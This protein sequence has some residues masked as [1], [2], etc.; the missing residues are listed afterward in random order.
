MRYDVLG[1]LEVSDDGR[2][3]EV[4]GRRQRALLAVLLLHANRV[5]PVERIVDALWGDEPP[6]TAAKAVQVL[7]S[8][9]RKALGPEPLVTKASGYM[10]RVGDGELDVDRFRRLAEE[11]RFAEALRLWRGP[12]L[13]EFAE[14]SFA[15]AEIARLDEQYLACV[16]ERVARDLDQGQRGELVGELERLVRE[17]PLRER[18]RAQLM[19]A[20][21]RSGRQAEALAAYQEARRTLV[22]ELGIEPGRALRELQQAI[23]QQNPILDL[24]DAGG[25]QRGAQRP[26]SSSFVARERELQE[27]F[28]GL[29]DAFARRARLFLVVG[30]PGIGKS[31]LCDEVIAHARA[32]GAQVLV[33][34]CWEAGGAPAYWPWVQALR[35]YVRDAD[36]A[37]LRAVL[38]TE[39]SDLAQLL[40]EL[41]ELF[42]DLPKP[43]AGE[44]EGARFRLFEAVASL[45]RAAAV[46]R[47]IVL[48][49]DDLHAADEP[50][51]VLLQFLARELG[52]D[53]LLVVGAYRDV[54]PTPTAPLRAALVEL[55]REPLTRTLALTGFDEDEVARFIEQVSGDEPSRQLVTAISD[56]TE[57]NPLFVSEILQ[58]IAAEGS[59]AAVAPK[60]VV[61]E[62]VREVILR[63]LRHLSKECRQAL[64][65]ASALGRE[66][67]LD[68]LAR[69]TNLSED[70][71]L[72]RLDEALA[73]GV[74]SD[75]PGASD[76]L[77]FAHV[78]IRDTLY[79][80][81][82][83]PRRVRLHRLTLQALEALETDELESHLAELAYHAVAASELDQG[84]SYACRAGDRALDSFAFE[85]AVRLYETA[86][87]ALDAAG[88]ADETLRYE[89]VLALGNARMLAGN[90]PAAKQ[91]FL[92]AADIARGTG[93]AERLARAALGYAGRG[94]WGP[95][96]EADATL[97]PLLEDALAQCG[98]V[99]SELLVNLLARLGSSLRGSI[100]RTRA[101][102]SVDRAVEIA[103]RLGDPRSLLFALGSR[104]AAI[105]TPETLVEMTSDGVDIV[106]LA[107][108]VGDADYE[109]SGRENLLYV[110]WT[111]GD[112]A[113]IA[114]E[115]AALAR[116]A[117]E[118]RQPA[119]TCSVA[120]YRAQIAL[121]EGELDE[122]EELI[123]ASA[124]A[125]DGADWITIASQRLQTFALRELRGDLDGYQD[126]IEA[127]LPMFP[128]YSILEC[129]LGAVYCRLGLDDEV[130]RL[131]DQLAR[132][133]FGQLSRD[134]DWL[135]NMSL[136]GDVVVSLGDRARAEVA[137]ELLR[138]FGGL[139]AY[140]QMEIGRGAVDRN[141]GCLATLLGR[142]QEA[143]MHFRAAV[144]M[145]ERMGARPWLA[146]TRE[147]WARML[148]DRGDARERARELLDAALAA[149]RQLGMAGDAERCSALVAA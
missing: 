115:L 134:E 59:F 142:Y 95:R 42:P 33:G 66:F 65:F 16:E 61:P 50:S 85:E 84:C 30:E 124:R 132:D 24:A 97:V 75:L 1:P 52:D 103:G 125:G 4:T 91:T 110:A 5:V 128:G 29:D 9:L 138:P 62:S 21:Y 111:R 43:S 68:A 45:L 69:L 56:E 15:A 130:R 74:V 71:L 11:G 109:F 80:G 146:R 116:L 17:H 83:T 37:S 96:A 2:P 77:R 147:D 105:R 90:V 25:G 41:R 123:E 140:A 104:V 88:R 48:V 127:S 3:V 63:R 137:Y 145:N 92:Q 133:D 112:R 136:L 143:E 35:V 79:E 94:L 120:A 89:I 6:E 18:L 118:L 46:R 135:V 22:E 67:R 117:D 72:D 53:R 78:L 64:V 13:A 144:D 126:V 39:A 10:L 76:R 12:P 93:S 114:S 73:A 55:A 113:G 31:R 107:R 108:E 99:E 27:L 102:A 139:N 70:A 40:P 8:Q 32:R 20:L 149:Y 57:G 106:R 58:L 122:A 121:L 98:D 141:L 23:L 100:D 7:V 87:D 81:L 82:T 131:L 47:P 19:L 44:S 34:R 119:K 86:L 38:G 49:L 101:R 26:T 54:D 51:L 60:I 36:P 129:A 148:V 14:L 28:R